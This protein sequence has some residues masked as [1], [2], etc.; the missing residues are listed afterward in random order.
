VLSFKFS[1]HMIILEVG[2]YFHGHILSL[3]TAT[4]FKGEGLI[5]ITLIKAIAPVT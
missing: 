5:P 4:G 1:Y 2:T 3:T